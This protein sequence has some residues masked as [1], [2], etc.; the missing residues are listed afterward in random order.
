M[1]ARHV[2]LNISI[3][4]TAFR[5]EQQDVGRVDDDQQRNVACPDDQT[6]EL[7]ITTLDA[8]WAPRILNA[9]HSAG[10]T[11][12]KL[13]V[14]LPLPDFHKMASPRNCVETH[15]GH[16]VKATSAYTFSLAGVE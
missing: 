2:S 9:T 10:E 16:D 8:P 3:G 5:T 12:R 4:Q 6:L 14:I 11:H 15:E 7:T 1:H 13:L